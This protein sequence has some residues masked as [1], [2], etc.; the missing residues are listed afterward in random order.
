MRSLPSIPPLKEALFATIMQQTMLP[1]SM[2]ESR[3]LQFAE[4]F[5]KWNQAINLVA[6]ST[7]PTFWERHV[8]D[9]VQL[10]PLIQT[11]VSRETSE[12]QILDIGSGGGFPGVLLALL[13]GGKVHLVESDQRKA[14]FLREVSRLAEGTMIIHNQRIETL[15]PWQVEVITSRACASVL[16]L[17]EWLRLFWPYNPLSFFLKGP[18]IAHEL[19]EASVYWR[20]Q[21]QLHP[22]LTDTDGV[23]L[24][25]QQV[26]SL[27]H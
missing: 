18:K 20:F 27:E 3:L 24:Q 22:S 13:G 2:V 4:L 5:F 17:F 25:L 6:A 9:S 10:L 23:I 26:S 1:A 11:H 14:A 12:R 8:L 19:K 16:Q 15:T 7:L 21:E